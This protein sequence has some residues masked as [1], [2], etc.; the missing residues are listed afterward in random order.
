[1]LIYAVADIH[2]KPG[3]LGLV[4][5][6]VAEARPDCILAAG[7]LC[8]RFSGDPDAVVRALDGLG[9]PVLAVRGN[10][11]PRD[12]A[13]RLSAS[14]H[15]RALGGRRLTV[16]GADFAGLDGTV[17]L[18]FANRVGWREAG[19]LRAA[20][21][22]VDPDCAL[23]VHA[24]PRGCRDRVAGRFASGSRGLAELVAGQRPALVVCGHVHED[25]GIGW[26]DG[27]LVVNCALHGN[28]AG[29]LIRWEKGRQPEAEMV[30]A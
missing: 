12:L 1:M 9:V 3:R 16:A 28:L 22:L 21:D 14:A 13:R 15:V 8:A 27:V 26:L 10:S 7:D 18:P 25:A 23:V 24:P 2:G 11:D 4:A 19:T 30:P 20:R 5:R 6:K 29:A 17:P